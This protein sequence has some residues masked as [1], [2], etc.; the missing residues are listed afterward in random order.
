MKKILNRVVAAAMAVPMVLTQGAVMNVNAADT[1][2]KALTLSSFTAIP[3]DQ[4]V[5]TWNT[6]MLAVVAS[7][8]GTEKTIAKADFLEM[9]PEVNVYATLLKEI[10]KDAPDPVMTV[11]NN[12]VTV[13]GTA[14]LTSYAE[15]EVY[16]KVNKALEDAGCPFDVTLDTFNKTVEY[17]VTVDFG[18]LADSTTVKLAQVTLTCDGTDITTGTADYFKGLVDELEASVKTQIND[19]YQA[20]IDNLPAGYEEF[21]ANAD[22]FEADLTAAK[23][24][25]VI[26]KLE[27]VADYLSK[28]NTFE[29]SGSYATADEALAAAAKFI[30]NREGFYNFPASVDEAV[31]R[32]GNGFNKAIEVANGITSTNGYKL[33]ITVDDVA[34]LAKE[35]SN[36]EVAVSG[37]TYSVTFNIPDEEAA[38]VEAYVNANAE[39][40]MVYDYSYKVVEVNGVPSAGTA[41]LDI[42]R[43]IVL[44]KADDT[45]TTTTT[46]TTSDTTTTTTTTSDTDTSDTTTTTTTDTSDTTSDTTTTTTTSDTTSDSTTTTTTTDSIPAEFV[47]ESIEVVAGKGY[48]FSHDENA[49]DLASLVSELTLVG[50]LDGE[51]YTV[52]ISA[53]SFANYLTPEFATPAD[54]FNAVEGTAYVANTLGLTFTPSATMNVAENAD[55]TVTDLPTVYIGVKGDANL[56]GEVKIADAQLVLKYYA[57]MAANGTSSMNDDADLAVL[58]YFLADIDTESKAGAD[59]DDA[60]M[61][62]ADAQAILTYYA[63]MAAN[64]EASWS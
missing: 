62:I 9:I 47:L 22:Q 55:L 35:G 29:R 59:T 32:H 20:Q 4:T 34:T 45:T 21:A 52:A 16:P 49:F 36:F 27:K 33:N 3:A 15:S 46:T 41:S 51:A 44:K 13:K 60:K 40:G 14:D 7:M 54:Y 11:K 63:K 64:G 25:D 8:E 1:G 28:V 23:D 42:T 19:Q 2:A 57:E 5:S 61:T 39:D 31:A 17:A 10:M 24:L 53:D 58:A 26:K 37:G 43:E 18:S 30:N 50:T 6:K 38:E 56:D 12:T 48:Y